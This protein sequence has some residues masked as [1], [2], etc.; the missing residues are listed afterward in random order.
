MRTITQAAIT[1]PL[2]VF[3]LT[4]IA[5]DP[6]KE[7]INSILLHQRD[8]G[9][10]PKNIDYSEPVKKAALLQAKNEIDSTIDNG[11]TT[12]EMKILAQTYLRTGN[13][14]YRKAFIKGLKY[15]LKA[16]YNSGG[17]PQKFP[18]TSGY[19]G[20]ITFN[21]GAMIKVMRLLKQI[22]EESSYEFVDQDLRDLSNQAV[23]K[24]IFCLLECQIIVDGRRTVWCA[25]HD[26]D[27]F[28]PAKARSYELPSFSGSESVGIV[29]FLI[30]VQNP[31]KEISESIEAAIH[32]FRTHQ[33]KGYKV[34]KTPVPKSPRGFDRIVI[35][36]ADAPGMWARFYDLETIEP[37]FCSR[38][39]IP[40]R[41]LS[42]I[43]YERRNGY[44][45]YT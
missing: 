18:N 15:C 34:V 27:S 14:T 16:Q 45:W 39:G 43:S 10:W 30:G 17:W 2:I 37:F 8:S 9:G 23:Q 35:A 42:E 25:Q 7:T 12:E 5:E 22:A 13:E 6:S 11:A 3:F 36:D 31:S 32:W 38:D 33:I 41:K 4:A 19:H 20:H 28:L 40:K 21:D 1:I 44:S 29:R 26:Q 24:G